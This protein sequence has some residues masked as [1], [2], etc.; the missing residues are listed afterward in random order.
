M[1]YPVFG[2]HLSNN[3]IMPYA[4]QHL[5]AELWFQVFR[6]AISPL[7][8][9]CTEPF[10]KVT[11]RADYD[12]ATKRALALV[13]KHWKNLSAPLLYEAI[14]IRHGMGSLKHSLED[15]LGKW[16]KLVEVL[17]EYT[18]TDRLTPLEILKLCP[19]L[20]ILVRPNPSSNPHDPITLPMLRHVV[21]SRQTSGFARGMNS[22][23][24]VLARNTRVS[25]LTV[26]GQILDPNFS[27]G[28]SDDPVCLPE[29]TTL[30]LIQSRTVTL[31]QMH[32][33]LITPSLVHLVVD[34]V[35]QET[36]NEFWS[37]TLSSQIRRVDLGH[38]MQFSIHDHMTPLLRHC[39][40]LT[41]LNYYLHFTHP[42]VSSIQHTGLKNIGLHCRENL[43]QRDQSRR[44]IQEHFTLLAGSAFPALEK[45]VLHG[46]WRPIV[47]DTCFQLLFEK[48][49][50][51][52]CHLAFEDGTA[53]MPALPVGVHVHIS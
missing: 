16:V 8:F 27:I 46:D 48:V 13:C 26:A 43:C 31:H 52:K 5:P 29:L 41:T 40:S 45:V 39:T 14:V 10:Q 19:N 1:P 51:R 20:Q 36:S 38:N 34:S 30:R 47:S 6:R 33:N 15:G 35:C 12:L 3:A 7:P 25:V 22:L 4:L 28:R 37:S 42:P 24:E 53:V 49:Y 2:S 18:V 44:N 23:V 32:P 50:A 17:Y 21:W 11:I 9:D